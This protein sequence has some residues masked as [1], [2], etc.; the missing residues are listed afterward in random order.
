MAPPEPQAGAALGGAEGSPSERCPGGV[1]ILNTNPDASFV[2]VLVG[3]KEQAGYEEGPDT[4]LYYIISQSVL[5]VMKELS[6]WRWHP[7]PHS[8]SSF[9]DCFFSRPRWSYCIAV[10]FCNIR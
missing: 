6:T 5:K 8:H 9:F 4:L 1:L 10:V 2:Y 3:E 7:P